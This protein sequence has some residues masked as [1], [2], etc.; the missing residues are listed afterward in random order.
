MT[1]AEKLLAKFVENPTALHFSK[2]EKMMKHLGF[3]DF[4][5]QGSHKK[6]KHISLGIGL[7]I[8]V[9]HGDC[10]DNYKR[11]IAQIFKNNFV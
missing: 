6:F 10:K 5:F 9:H 1:R 4:G 2:I 8:P 7:S 11:N 3:I